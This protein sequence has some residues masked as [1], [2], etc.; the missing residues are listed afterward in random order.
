ME[1]VEQIKEA[2]QYIENNLTNDICPEDVSKHVFA[3]KS[4]FQRIFSVVTGIT[5]SDYIRNRRLSAAGLDLLLS[6]SKVIDIAMRY[7]YDTSESFSKAFTRFHGFAPSAV[8]MCGDKLKCFDPISID[9][10]IQGGFNMSRKIMSNDDGVRLIREKFEYKHVGHLRFIGVDCKRAGIVGHQV[11]E[12]NERLAKYLDPLMDKYTTDITGYCLLETRH[13]Q[14][15]DDYYQMLILGKFLK[16]NTP[17][18]D[19]SDWEKDCLY[20]YDIP[21]A[22]IG[23]GIYCGDESFGGDTFDAYVFTRDQILRD[24]VEIPYP[25]AYWTVA[26]YIEGE[27]KKGKYRFGYMFGVGDIKVQSF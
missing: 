8:K 1:W 13:G 18:P 12:A 25:H 7:Q 3:S 19:T 24:G 16:P 27:P 11:Q 5:I 10:L 15:I 20:Y 14:F 4:H 2:V 26:Q 23:Y 22:N 6:K 9:I 17:L 21:T